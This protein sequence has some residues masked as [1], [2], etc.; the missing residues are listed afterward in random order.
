MKSRFVRLSGVLVFVLL[1]AC[2]RGGEVKIVDGRVTIPPP[3]MRMAAG[4]FTIENGTDQDIEV[5]SVSSDAFESVGM[6]ETRTENGVSS[7]PFARVR[8]DNVPFG[9]TPRLA[10]KTAQQKGSHR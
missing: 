8:M 3:G 4:Y 7:S 10:V 6:H 5:R 1:G 2:G 9:K